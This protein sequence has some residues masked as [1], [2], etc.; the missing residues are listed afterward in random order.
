MLYGIAQA[1]LK[2][3][4]RVVSFMRTLAPVL[5]LLVNVHLLFPARLA[6]NMAQVL[7]AH[8]TPRRRILGLIEFPP[9]V[10]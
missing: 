3:K 2:I 8:V 5:V 7:L 9:A 10:A 6:C 4:I 1:V